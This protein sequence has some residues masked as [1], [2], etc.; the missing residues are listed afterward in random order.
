MDSSIRADRAT[1]ARLQKAM[2]LI[3]MRGFVLRSNQD[4]INAL[5]DLLESN[6]I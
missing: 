3:A 5:L 2:P 4:A 1:V 6:L